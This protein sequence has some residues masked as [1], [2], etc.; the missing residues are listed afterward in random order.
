MD[1]MQKQVTELLE[2]AMKQPGVAE[3]VQLY[4]SQRNAMNAYTQARQA[5]EPHWIVTSSTT[6]SGVH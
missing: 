5:N 6:S 1:D 3:V 2:K 4:E